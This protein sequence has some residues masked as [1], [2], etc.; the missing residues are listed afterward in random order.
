M[1]KLLSRDEFKTQVFARTKGKCVFC[2][3]PASDAHHIMDRKLFTDGGYRLSNGAA[4][5]NDCHWK[6]EITEITVN[7]VLKAC[8]LTQPL[9][10]TGFHSSATYDKWGNI[11]LPNGDRIPGPLFN[12]TGTQRALQ[13]GKTLWRF[14]LNTQS[15]Q[16]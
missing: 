2:G 11:I 13:K 6:C 15:E 8:G 1:D 12:D 4:V 5:C 10:P 16:T 3:Q 14:I 7:D 9:L